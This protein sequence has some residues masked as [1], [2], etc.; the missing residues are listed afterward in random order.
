MDFEKTPLKFV[1]GQEKTP[2]KSG[3]LARHKGVEPLTF[4]SVAIKNAEE[5]ALFTTRS[6]RIMSLNTALNE[7][8]LRKNTQKMQ[9][10]YIS[11][12]TVS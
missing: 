7:P 9:Q 11:Y 2:E 5:S 12:K 6:C 8:I 3:V 1:A 10:K 4:G